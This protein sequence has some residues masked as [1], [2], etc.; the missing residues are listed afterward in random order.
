MLFKRKITSKITKDEAARLVTSSGLH[1]VAFVMDGNGRWAKK[2]SMPRE[3]GHPVGAATF[4]KVIRYCGD[5]GIDTITVYAL[6]TENLKKRPEVELHQIFDLL[7]Q[8]IA[9]AAEKNKE[10][11]IKVTF[12]GDTSALGEMLHKKCVDLEELTADNT[13]KLN[14]ALNYGGRAEIAYAVNRL[15]SE[16]V[17]S[18]S[19]DDISRHIYTAYCGDPD[20]IVR[21][22]GDFRISNFLL[23]QS[24]YS[25]LYFTDCLWPDFGEDEVNCAVKSFAERSRRYGGV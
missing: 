3:A 9:D 15:I 16:G 20:L 6:S 17:E 14:I 13:L 19:E 2:R 1:H 22:G 21:T 8:Y 18:V 7:E 24:A 4:K 5:I 10:N 25:E 12:I 11:N 23:W